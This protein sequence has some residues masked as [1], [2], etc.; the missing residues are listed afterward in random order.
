M[1]TPTLMLLCVA[2]MEQNTLVIGQNTTDTSTY[3]KQKFISH[4]LEGK[5]GIFIDFHGKHIDELLCYIPGYR[6]DDITLLDLSEKEHV[7]SFNIFDDIDV[8]DRPFVSSSFVSAIKAVTGYT[9]STPRLDRVVYN[10]SRLALD[11][12]ATMLGMFYLL[13]KSEYRAELLRNCTDI[14]VQ[15]FWENE[16]ASKSQKDKAEYVSSA[17]NNIEP[18]ITNTSLRNI[19]GQKQSSFSIKNIMSTGTVLLISLPRHLLG[20]DTTRLLGLLLL[21]SIHSSARYNNE[22]FSLYIDNA[23]PVMSATLQHLFTDLQDH[24]VITKVAVKQLSYLKGIPLLDSVDAIVSFKTGVNDSEKL[25]PIF[26]LGDQA[27]QQH[28]LDDLEARYLSGTRSSLFTLEPNTQELF[29]SNASVRRYIKD[30]RGT[31]RQKVERR[32]NRFI[33]GLQ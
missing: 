30:H 27:I 24:H 32:I 5:G 4:L 19:I 14:A 15:D 28:E 13:T 29:T 10:A 7:R 17:L 11:N 8:D 16:F 21:T 1:C 9:E 18:F 22:P 31:P 25:K 20:N 26:S 12:N 2:F 23:E 3:L 6:R 33:G